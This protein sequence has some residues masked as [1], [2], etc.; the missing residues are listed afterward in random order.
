MLYFN[1]YH[2]T[3]YDKTDF[4]RR[5]V[6]S[7]NPILL[8]SFDDHLDPK[9]EL[10]T[11]REVTYISFCPYD[12]NIVIGGT[13]N[14][15]LIIWDM[16]DRLKN[17][18]SEE[19]L[20]I[21]QLKYRSAMRRF[22]SWTKE[23]NQHK[24]VRPVAI[25]SLE[26]SQKSAITAIEWFNQRHFVAATGVVRESES[27]DAKNRY[28]ATASADGTI[29]FWDLS[30]SN[31]NENKKMSKNRKKRIPDFMVHEESE[32]AK[33][34]ELFCPLFMIIYNQ[35]VTSIIMDHGLFK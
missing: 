30:F 23:S 8:W 10:E 24:V 29:A 14:G 17:V 21:S 31:A 5:A 2:V 22:L 35:P 13:I 26:Q 6:L 34:N 12:E 15:Q 33:L 27:P 7:P 32:Y 4:V 11:P 9:L 3:A 16:K 25:S 1:L 28:F 20:T 18:E 19:V